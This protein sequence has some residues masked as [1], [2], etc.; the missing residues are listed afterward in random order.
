MAPDIDELIKRVNTLTLD[1][2][3][4]RQRL[5]QLSLNNGTQ[6][7]NS[8]KEAQLF[9]PSNYATVPLGGGGD[10]NN[11]RANEGSKAESPKMSPTFSNAST[12]EQLVRDK[13]SYNLNV[14]SGIEC[15][16]SCEDDLLYI[17]ELYKNRLE[18]Y[19]DNWD[20]L[21]SKCS[22][23][24]SELNALQKHYAILKA[25]KLDLEE[26]LK[27]SCDEHD[28]VKSEL[29]TVVINYESQLS[30]MSEHLSMITSQV[31]MDDNLSS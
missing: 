10:N 3:R 25:E 27:N 15:A 7:V 16:T 24:L 22:A 18:E 20:F 4:L 1:K 29:Q 2:N 19:D 11:A 26:K 9:Y 13:T 31:N 12:N 23:L 30:A 6:T 8:S 21:Q 5:N 17:N 28:K 14:I